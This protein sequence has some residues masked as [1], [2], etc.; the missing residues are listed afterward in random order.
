MDTFLSGLTEIELFLLWY[1]SGLL[2]AIGVCL[3]S[4]SLRVKDI[5][6]SLLF[7]VFGPVLTIVSIFFLLALGWMKL[8]ESKIWDMELLPTK[9]NK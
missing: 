1:L 4:G 9:K 5:L 7:A 8:S 2:S 6:I 3:L